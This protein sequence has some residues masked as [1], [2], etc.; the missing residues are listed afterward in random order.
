[1]FITYRLFNHQPHDDVDDD[2]S[3]LYI[4]IRL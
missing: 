3:L 4:T 2:A 1:L